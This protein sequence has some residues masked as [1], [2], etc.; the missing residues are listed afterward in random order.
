M[1]N[2]S[3]NK[4]IFI[5][6]SHISVDGLK[7]GRGNALICLDVPLISKSQTPG[8]IAHMKRGHVLLLISDMTVSGAT[9]AL[10]IQSLSVVISCLP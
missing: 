6:E 5:C 8:L 4:M 2:E 1:D 3:I 10:G 9:A 7:V